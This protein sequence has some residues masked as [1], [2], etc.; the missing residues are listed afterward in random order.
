MGSATLPLPNQLSEA[1]SNEISRES[2]VIANVIEE[3]KIGKTVGEALKQFSHYSGTR[4]LSANKD[5]IAT[6]KGTN[7]RKFGFTWTF[8]PTS[9][10]EASQI[11]NIIKLFKQFASP[12]KQ[13]GGAVLISPY[14][15]WI[16]V[17]NK[18]MNDM[19][20]LNEMLISDVT[21]TYGSSGAMEMFSD[22]FPKEITMAV[23]VVERRMKT[24]DMW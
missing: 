7:L 19:L 15:C 13:I 9:Q 5:W 18:E 14:Y 12:E 6:Y 23:S 22:A 2:G 4:T 10:E 21:V 1:L 24:I 20:K 3:S 16:E 8:N 17:S 11:K